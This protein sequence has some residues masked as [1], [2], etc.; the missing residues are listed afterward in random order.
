MDD[1]SAPRRFTREET[2][3]ILRRATEGEQRLETLLEDGLT[4]DEL[5]RAA[6]AAGIDVA[7]VRRAAAITHDPP[8]PLQTWLVAAPVN[9][10]TSR[11][12][13]TPRSS[14]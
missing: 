8:D 10:V 7:A 9:P 12:V 5:A 14:S 2:A 3:L 1:P 4:L 6:E 13:F 11:L